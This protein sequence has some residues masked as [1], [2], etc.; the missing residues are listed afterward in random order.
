MDMAR[1]AR[2]LEPGELGVEELRAAAAADHDDLV[3][4]ELGGGEEVDLVVD[5]EPV[6]RRRPWPRARARGRRRSSAGRRRPG[7]RGRPSRTRKTDGQQVDQPVARLDR[8]RGQVLDGLEVEE[9]VAA[10]GVPA[11]P[12]HPHAVE[13]VAGG[14][15]RVGHRAG[16]D[17]EE[18]VVDGGAVVPFSTISIASMSPPASPMAP[19]QRPSEPGTSGSSTRKRKGMSTPYR[20][21]QTIRRT[22]PGGFGSQQSVSGCGPRAALASPVARWAWVSTAAR[23]ASSEPTTRTCSWARVTA[24]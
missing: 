4:V 15:D 20:S 22:L 2:W 12:Q 1:A 16:R 14:H 5:L 6:R 18:D 19:R 7:R 3:A 8:V 24:V 23:T 11:D 9:H 13:G 10:G 21:H 17:L